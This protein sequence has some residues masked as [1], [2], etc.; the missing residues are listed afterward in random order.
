MVSSKSFMFNIESPAALHL[1]FVACR[2]IVFYV[3]T[4]IRTGIK[5]IA[6]VA[7]GGLIDLLVAVAAL[8]SLGMWWAGVLARIGFIV[9]PR[10]SL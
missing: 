10:T 5:V 7:R 1:C 8:T 2:P 9:A 3:A 4:G 6:K